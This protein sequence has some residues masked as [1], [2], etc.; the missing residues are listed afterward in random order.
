MLVSALMGLDV[1]QAAYAHAIDAG[2][3]LLQLRRREPA[4]AG[5]GKSAAAERVGPAG[6]HRGVERQ[7]L[8]AL[9]ARAGVEGEFAE[10]R[11]APRLRRNRRG[12]RRSP[13]RAFRRPRS[14]GRAR[15]GAAGRGRRW[16][17]TRAANRGR[18]RS[19]GG[20]RRGR[21]GPG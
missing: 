7:R 3:P 20:W 16:L 6:A 9:E 1:M 13:R 2:L 18:T 4:A 15:R 14:S 17:A 5:G 10:Q 11:A 8:D 12:R 19:S 21:D